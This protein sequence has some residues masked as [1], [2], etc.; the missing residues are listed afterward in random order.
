MRTTE[1]V[2]GFRHSAPY[3]NAHRGKTFVVML[4]GEALAQNQFRAILNDVALLHSLGI[5]VVLVY[6]ARPQIDA[7]LAINGIE[8]T[9]HEGVRITDEESLKVIKQVAGALQFDITARLSMSLSNTPMQGAQINLVSGNFVIAQ[10]LGVD[11]GIDFCLSGR[12]RR[13]DVQGLKRQL[14]NH[15]IVL[16]GPI[17]ASVTGESFNLTAEE[18]AT[19]VAIKLKADKMIGFS[20]QNGILDRNGDVIAELMPNDAQNIMDKLSEQGSACVGTM[21]FLKASIDACR[22][23]VP[24]C[25]L[26][27][28]LEDGALL[29]EL[30]SREGIGTQIV[31]ESAERLRSASIA[32][33]GGVLNLIRP[34]EEQGILVRRSREQLEIEIEQFML[35]ERDGLVIGCA[36]LY[37]F[38]E[39][40]AGEF[41]C[42][43][44]HPDYRD[45]DRGSLLLKNII[46][47]ARNRGYSRLFALTT[48]SI[49]WFLEHGFVIEDVEALP[50]KKKQLYNYQRR[51]K[52]LALDL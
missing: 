16:M 25:H 40:N 4:G 34:L 14:D 36:A 44:V 31:T 43:V 47:K 45:A 37:P 15:C 24:R 1:L 19:Q 12:V 35:I 13:I 22:N 3:V 30:F 49:H 52:I 9:Y 23:G 2:D 17:A 27:S 26:V 38:E 10:P 5:K 11:N 29:Q 28:Y 39:D 8:P 20:S 41:A 6:G 18:I 33:I 46:N 50:Q 42:L 48:R 32:D 7:A 21:A 51:S